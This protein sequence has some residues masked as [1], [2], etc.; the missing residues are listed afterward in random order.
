MLEYRRTLVNLDTF[1]LLLM[2]LFHE[3]DLK[4]SANEC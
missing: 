1:E 2:T 4:V 3:E